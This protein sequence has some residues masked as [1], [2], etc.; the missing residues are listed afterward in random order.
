[1]SKKVVIR[2][3]SDRSRRVVRMAEVPEDS[4][5]KQEFRDECDLNIIVARAM[6]GVPP[7]FINQAEPMYG[8]FSEM[9]TIAQAH[10]IVL[11][12]Q[13]SF[14]TLPA[15]LRRELGNDPANIDELTQEQL[16]R[17]GLLKPQE[18]PLEAP[19]GSSSASG[20]QPDPREAQTPPKGSKSPS[21]APKEPSSDQGGQD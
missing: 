10:E 17:Y 2:R 19:G 21:K 5:T 8:D 13:E 20:G 6:K 11:A 7:V 12:A 4:V 1:M 15:A 14:M 18:E 3:W 9:P 16:Q